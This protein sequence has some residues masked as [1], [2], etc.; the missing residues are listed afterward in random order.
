MLHTI[1]L[2]KVIIL[3]FL[4]LK[5]EEKK[6]IFKY[7]INIYSTNKKNKPINSWSLA[8]TGAAAP[9]G[10]YYQLPRIQITDTILEE[11]KHY[12]S[13]HSISIHQLHLHYYALVSTLWTYYNTNIMRLYSFLIFS[14]LIYENE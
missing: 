14:K 3:F 12:R 10:L 2:K 8:E 5:F 9:V 7:Y 6:I 1:E 4:N 11:Q 13:I